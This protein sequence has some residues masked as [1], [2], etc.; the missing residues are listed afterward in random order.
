MTEFQSPRLIVIMGVCGSGKSTLAQALALRFGYHY[1]DADDYH[2]LQCK[3]QMHLGIPLDDENRAA[4]I[5][6]MSVIIDELADKG[7]SCV[8]AYSGIRRAQRRRIL[9]ARFQTIGFMLTGSRECLDAR[10]HARSG[11][12]MSP[13]LLDSQLQSMQA[14]EPDEKITL[15]DCARPINSL[16]AMVED[17]LANL[18]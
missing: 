13:L 4:W 10:M 16:V 18:E 1:L 9:G 17:M 7:T 2:T 6:R 11:H 5:E 8:L 14:P 15:L 12:F 3:E